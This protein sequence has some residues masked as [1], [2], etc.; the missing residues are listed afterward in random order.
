MKQLDFEHF[1]VPTGIRGKSRQTGDARESMADLVYLNAGGIRAHKLAFKIY[2][3]S[4]PTEYTDEE[5]GL[6]KGLVEK[7]AL[8]NII[9]GLNEQL[10]DGKEKA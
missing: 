7:Y 4:G 5:A 10:N 6:I 1:S 2:E 8:P 3:S 9:D